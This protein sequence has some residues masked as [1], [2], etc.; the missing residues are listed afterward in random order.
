MADIYSIEDDALIVRFNSETV[1]IEA[2]GANAIRTR[3]RPG[4]SVVESHVSALLEPGPAKAEISVDGKHACIRNGRIEARVR[5]TRRLGGGCP[6]GAGSQLLRC[7]QSQGIA[8]GNPPAF[9]RPSPK[10]IQIARFRQLS[11]GGRVQGL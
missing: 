4:G 10:A 2:W 11:G 1:R 3:A 7:N 5:M 8:G 9:C 6:P